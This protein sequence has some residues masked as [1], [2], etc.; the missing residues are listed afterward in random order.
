M[1]SIRR[2]A[3]AFLVALLATLALAPASA[4]DSLVGT[5][6]V[7]PFDQHGAAVAFG[8]ELVFVEDTCFPIATETRIG[9]YDPATNLAALEANVV[10]VPLS[11]YAA[12]SDGSGLYLFGGRHECTSNMDS[13]LI[14][15]YD[16]AT[17]DVELA[18]SLPAPRERGTTAVWTGDF[19]YVLGGGLPDVVR[20]DPVTKAA[21]PLPVDLPAGSLAG[22]AFFANPYIYVPLRI[23]DPLVNDAIVRVNVDTWVVERV[24][25]IR[26]VFDPLDSTTAWTG[27]YAYFFGGCCNADH[28][29]RYDPASNELVQMGHDGPSPPWGLQAAWDGDAIWLL[30]GTVWEYVP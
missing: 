10:P 25:G 1:T 4:A 17:G 24:L 23:Q 14:W 7:L 3:S 27:T 9:R 21:V 5:G 18:G 8:S 26:Q 28:I 15:R 2:K 19:F 29:Y 6:A 22:E 20:Y 12:A 16:L 30:Q 11:D 13:P